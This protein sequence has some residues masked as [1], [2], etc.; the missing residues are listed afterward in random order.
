MAEP[1]EPCGCLVMG[2]G[3]GGGGGG[4]EGRRSL[5]TALIDASVP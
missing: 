2:G 1:S 5:E 4:G 3:G